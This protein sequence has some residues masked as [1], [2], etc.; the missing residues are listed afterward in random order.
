MNELFV[1]TIFKLVHKSG[2]DDGNLLRRTTIP[3]T[4]RP[5]IKEQK[6]A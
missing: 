6:L 3:L 4:F 2:S 5:V 1:E